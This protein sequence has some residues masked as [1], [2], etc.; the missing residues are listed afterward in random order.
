DDLR[1]DSIALDQWD[2]RIIGDPQPAFRDQDFVARVRWPQGE[3]LR[4]HGSPHGRSSTGTYMRSFGPTYQSSGLRRRLSSQY[5]M[6]W[7]AHPA[8]RAIAKTGVKR[9]VGIPRPRK[10]RP[11]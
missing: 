2:N 1:P 3:A 4:G 9:S 7:A 10:T 6:T 5:S 8:I 11:A